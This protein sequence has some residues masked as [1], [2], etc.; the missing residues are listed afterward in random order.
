MKQLQVIRAVVASPSDVQPERNCI[1]E[2][3]AELNRSIAKNRALH[4]EISRWETDTYP[5]FHVEGPQ[6]WIDQVLRI[7]ECDLLIGIFWKRFGTPTADAKSGTEHEFRKAYEAWKLN[8]RPQIMIYFNE[9]KYYPQTKAETDQW[10]QVL[11]FKREFPKEGLWWRYI[12]KPQFE[13][14]VRNHL[15]QFILDIPEPE[16]GYTI[17]SSRSVSRTPTH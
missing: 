16:D 8:Q 1:E 2:V 14:Q 9:R 15:T 12:G 6:G 17:T 5:G 7:E 11:E 13:K 10:G 3:A 4:I